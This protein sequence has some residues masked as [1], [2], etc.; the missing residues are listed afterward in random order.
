MSHLVTLSVFY[1]SLLKY[2]DPGA[3]AKCL[4]RCPALARFRV[5]EH[6][7]AFISKIALADKSFDGFR[8]KLDFAFAL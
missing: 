3:F 4:V 5:S 7:V 2:W 8:V 6:K 1:L